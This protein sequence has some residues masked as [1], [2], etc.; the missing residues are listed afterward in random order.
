MCWLAAQAWV[1]GH[2]MV[3]G[4]YMRDDQRVEVAKF[5]WSEDPR[6]TNAAAGFA[7]SVTF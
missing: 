1:M 5:D 6:V 4:T 3:P 2:W 7:L